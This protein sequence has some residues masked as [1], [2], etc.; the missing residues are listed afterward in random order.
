MNIIQVDPGG[1][2]F[3]ETGG[4][5]T[6]TPWGCNYYD[7]FTGWPPRIWGQF[8]P[9]RVAAHFDDIRAVGG[10][11]IRVFTALTNV[12][13]GPGAVSAAGIGRME[14]MLSLAAER[15]IRVIWSGPGQWE[16]A[17]AWWR[18]QSLYEGYARPDLIEAQQAAWRGIAGAMR[19][20]PGLFSYEL[21]NEPFSPWK[22]TPAVRE[23]WSKWRA[24]HAPGAPEDVPAPTEPLLADWHP[25][26]QLFREHVADAYVER[27]T[28]AI[29]PADDTH[30]ITI[31]LH[32]KSAPFD[33][34]PPDPYTAFNPHR[35]ARLVDYTSIHFYPHHAFHPSIYRDPYETAEGMRETLAHARATTRYFHAAGKP[36]VMEECG[37]YGGG[38][39]LLNNREMPERTEEDQATWCRG[40]VE[41]TRGDACGWLFWPYRDTP[42]SLDSSRRSGFYLPEGGLKEWGR[43]FARMAP[44]I[45]R[46]IPARD[47]GT[48]EQPVD[49]LELATN[50]EAVKA[51]RRR[52]IAAFGRGVTV[53]FPLREG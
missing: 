50:P 14:T 49:L 9:G 53:N 28:D 47:P 45:T 11:V 17:P 12:L 25:Q 33:W 18:E 29:R 6:F 30:L 23:A 20:H 5:P 41:A 27:M 36:V 43:V 13:E 34:Y 8:D 38:S 51:F 2:G 32:Q 40:L 24:R 37:W 42:S 35:L 7:P 4:G 46:A 52:Y 1:W 31:G 3:R 16:G 39:I 21:H 19:G 44:E 48:V 22:A 15:G 26:F 10:N